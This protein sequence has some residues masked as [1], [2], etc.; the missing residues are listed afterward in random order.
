[1]YFIPLNFG[2]VLLIIL[3]IHCKYLSRNCSVTFEEQTLR[4]AHRLS[5]D[6]TDA[7]YRCSLQGSVYRQ[8]GQ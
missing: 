1:M 6:C 3:L 2:D 4:L 7:T 8:P 5:Q